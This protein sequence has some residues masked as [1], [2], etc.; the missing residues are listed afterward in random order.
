MSGSHTQRELPCKEPPPSLYRAATRGRSSLPPSLLPPSLWQPRAAGS[1]RMKR[2][3]LNQSSISAQWEI[4]QKE[5]PPFLY[6]AISAISASKSSPRKSIFLPLSGSHAKQQ[7]PQ[8]TAP[9][10]PLSSSSAQAGAFRLKSLLHQSGSSTQRDGAPRQ[11]LLPR[12][13]NPVMRQLHPSGSLPQRASSLPESKTPA[14]LDI[15]FSPRN[16]LLTASYCTRL[17]IPVGIFRDFRASSASQ[18]NRSFLPIA[19][20][21]RCG[22]AAAVTSIFCVVF[23]INFVAE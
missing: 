11:S 19:S 4:S 6:L 5:P 23:K 18:R 8:K 2:L 1:P 10:I 20:C 9:F 16:S 17:A 12:S 22:D 21:A 7:L 14:Q 15:P 13:L 3:F